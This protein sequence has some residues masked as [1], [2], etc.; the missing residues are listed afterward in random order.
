METK[1]SQLIKENILLVKAVGKREEEKLNH[2]QKENIQRPNSNEI[3]YPLQVINKKIDKN[4][5]LDLRNI[6]ISECD[7]RVSV[8][9]HIIEKELKEASERS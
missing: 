8:D 3:S 9:E 1:L 5:R 7:L 4:K 6:N 2:L